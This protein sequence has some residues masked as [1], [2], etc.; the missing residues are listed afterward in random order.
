MYGAATAKRHIAWSNSPTV[1]LLDLGRMVM[2]FHK[3]NAVQSTRKY[4]NKRGKVSF[5]GSPFLK[6]TQSLEVHVVA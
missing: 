4:K 3:Q 5:C 6:Q 2:A 1:T